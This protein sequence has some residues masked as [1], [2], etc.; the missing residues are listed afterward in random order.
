[1]ATLF[2]ALQN[3]E[4]NIDSAE[5]VVQPLAVSTADKSTDIHIG[6]GVVIVGS[7]TL[8]GHATVN[9]RFEGE[10]HAGSLDVGQTGHVSGKV[11]AKTMTISGELNKEIECSE[12]F[13]IKSTGKVSGNLIY[14]GLQID[15]GGSFQGEMKEI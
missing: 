1:M 11:F 14:A 9:G 15:R 10:I 7:I 12:H 13:H 3:N 5:L 4:L 6:D 8:P 2:S